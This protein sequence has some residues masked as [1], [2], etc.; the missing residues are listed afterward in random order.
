[1]CDYD[2]EAWV[3]QAV[4]HLQQ[5]EAERSEARDVLARMAPP[6]YH[7]RSA[8]AYRRAVTDATAT[9]V[10]AHA[11]IRQYE[12]SLALHSAGADPDEWGVFS[13]APGISLEDTLAQLAAARHGHETLVAGAAAVLILMAP[14]R[15]AAVLGDV[16][17][18]T[19]IERAVSA[20]VTQAPTKLARELIDHLPARARPLPLRIEDL[21]HHG[22]Y[23]LSVTESRSK[24][25]LHDIVIG[26]ARG[27]GFGTS[28]L[29][30]LCRYADHR[31]LPIVCTMVV[32]SAFGLPDK[33]FDAQRLS[34]E[35][36]LAAWYHRHGFRA[37]K[38]LNEWKSF[39]RLR[40]EPA[41][42]YSPEVPHGDAYSAGA[43]G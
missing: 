22:T 41:A 32:D 20:L 13:L 3:L 40:R 1:M 5:A 17:P 6:W 8:L 38:P 4:H 31:S 14:A 30:E 26:P 24:I 43:A 12:R 42:R 23:N 21:D 33:E 28:L 16:L 11:E 10:R 15:A 18:R 39:T 2:A 37:D 27:R 19:E 35:R 25:R 9:F 29:Q 34:D 7:L 36:R